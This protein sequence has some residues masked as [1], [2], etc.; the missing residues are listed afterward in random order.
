M[1]LMGCSGSGQHGSE[2]E[3]RIEV[4]QL[5]RSDKAV[6]GGGTFATAVGACE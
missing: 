5:G 6:H 1:R 2:I 4:V 3:F